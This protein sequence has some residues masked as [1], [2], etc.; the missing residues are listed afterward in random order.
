LLRFLQIYFLVI[1]CI[2]SF[3]F[4]W[5]FHISY[6]L[7]QHIIV[8]TTDKTPWILFSSLIAHFGV[9]TNSSK[10][11]KRKNEKKK[12]NRRK[13]AAC[14]L[15]NHRQSITITSW[16]ERK[17]ERVLY[18]YTWPSFSFFSSCLSS[19]PMSIENMKELIEKKSKAKKKRPYS[20]F[21]LSFQ[22]NKKQR[23]ISDRT[24]VQMSNHCKNYWHCAFIHVITTRR[25]P[26]YQHQISSSNICVRMKD[27]L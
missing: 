3:Y 24:A 8:V 26:Y 25:H 22:I 18:N 12:K 1:V 7:L 13:T 11:G 6:C 2:C 17:K 14:V 19:I 10:S 9:R 21:I 4:M 20:F 16:A 23:E 27:N 5:H 15:Y